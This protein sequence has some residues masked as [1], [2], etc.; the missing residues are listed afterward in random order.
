M[1]HRFVHWNKN[2]TAYRYPFVFQLACRCR[3]WRLA[4]KLI[5]T[6]YSWSRSL[7]HECQ[8]EHSANHKHKDLSSPVPALG[9]STADPSFDIAQPLLPQHRQINRGLSRDFELPTSSNTRRGK[10]ASAEKKDR[11]FAASGP[12]R[13]ASMQVIALWRLTW[14]NTDLC[15]V[16]EHACLDVQ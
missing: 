11:P 4:W 6:A 2:L 1:K 13:E 15:K 8:R 16:P 10:A 9:K 5:L 3:S 12:E 7:G 14:G